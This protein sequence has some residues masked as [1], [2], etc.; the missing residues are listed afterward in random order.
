MRGKGSGELD[1][2]KERPG[3]VDRLK[4]EGPTHHFF[5][6]PNQFLLAA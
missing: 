5:A 1:I 6:Q 4:A 3:G 2:A